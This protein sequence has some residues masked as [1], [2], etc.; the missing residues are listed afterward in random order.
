MRPAS[1]RTDAAIPANCRPDEVRQNKQVTRVLHDNWSTQVKHRIAD[2]VSA[3]G[4]HEQ[5]NRF[6]ATPALDRKDAAGRRNG[7]HARQ[8][9][10][11]G[12]HPARLRFDSDR[13]AGE[14]A[15]PATP[16]SAHRN[17]AVHPANTVATRHVV[18]AQLDRGQ[19]SQ[20]PRGP[21]DLRFQQRTERAIRAVPVRTSTSSPG[22][23][24]DIRI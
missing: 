19:P 17:K 11:D 18:T 22:R 10:V 2:Q 5:H 23:I 7:E 12:Q 1:K 8:A 9:H 4:R 24:I 16:T 6:Q 14:P 3:Y 15:R 13:L 20:R 21:I